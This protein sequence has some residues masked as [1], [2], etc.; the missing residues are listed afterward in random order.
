M[1][2]CAGVYT[3]PDTLTQT[4]TNRDAHTY[5]EIDACAQRNTQVNLTHQTSEK[6][7]LMHALP[8][9]AQAAKQVHSTVHAPSKT[10]HSTCTSQDGLPAGI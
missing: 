6:K 7:T 10:Q 9:E 1:R 4:Q 3:H 5:K 8:Q 2:A